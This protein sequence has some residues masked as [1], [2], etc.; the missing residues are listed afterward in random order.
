MTRRANGEGSVYK[1]RHG[2]WKGALTV[3]CIGTRQIRRYRT[4]ATRASVLAKL[5]KLRNELKLSPTADTSRETLKSFATRWLDEHVKAH[6]APN[7]EALYRTAA[8]LYV[9]PRLGD[10]QL[11]KINQAVVQSFVDKLVMDAVPSRMR[12]V[13]FDVLG[14]ALRHAIKLGQIVSDP[15]RAVEKPSHDPEEIF[16]FD[17][18]DAAAIIKATADTRW[19]AAIVLAL[20]TGMRIGELLGMRWSDV[21]LQERRLRITQQAAQTRGVATIRKPKTKSSV[22]TIELPAIAVRALETHRAILLREGSAASELVFPAPTGG[23]MLRTNFA[24]RVW[25]PLLKRL[26]IKERGFHHARHTYATLALGA[27]VPVHVVSRVLGHSKPST[28]LD[29]Y[30]HVLKGQQSQATAAMEKLFA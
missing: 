1:T 24:A 14:R 27:G 10:F 28:T 30:A 23:I 8:E 17:A 13:A 11:S 18:T 21:E 4:A 6:R 20:T 25:I 19:H 2:R 12:Q 3:G 5:E 29:I 26:G 16:P 7:T 15:T 22:R 9:F